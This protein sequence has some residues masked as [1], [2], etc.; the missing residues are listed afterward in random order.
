MDAMYQFDGDKIDWVE[1]DD[2]TQDYPCK[3]SMSIL[4]ADAET[5][6]IDLIVKLSLIHI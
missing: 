6:R 2:P 1:F 3:Y 5:G 4:G